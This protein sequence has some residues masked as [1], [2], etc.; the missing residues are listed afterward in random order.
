MTG[1]GLS[2]YNEIT[3]MP[4]YP[5]PKAAFILMSLLENK[6]FEAYIVGGYVRD[7]L[8]GRFG[9][10]IDM[11][12]NASTQQMIELFNDYPLSRIG[13]KLGTIGVKVMD[14]WIEITTYRSEGT[15]SNY[16]HPDEVRFIGSLKDDVL[17]RDFTINAMA[18][19]IYGDLIDYTEGCIDLQKRQIRAIGLPEER[20][21][22]DALRILRA[23]R[24][25]V[26]LGFTIEDKTS[27]AMMKAQDLIKTLPIER[28]SVE[29]D[30]LIQS[31]HLEPLFRNYPDLLR[32]C[33]DYDPQHIQ[34][35]DRFKDK[36]LRYLC[37]L[38]H[39]DA[40]TIKSQLSHLKHPK[41]FIQ[42]VSS[43]KILSN[44]QTQDRYTM[45]TL[46][47]TYGKALILLAIE[48]QTA[49]NIKGIDPVMMNQLIE[50]DP[51]VNLKDLAINGDDLLKM[52][53]HGKSIKD[54][55]N[56][57]L[58]LVMRDEVTNDKT[59]LSQAVSRLS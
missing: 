51:C 41:R 54:I 7:L 5:I 27:L 29:F 48:Y 57:L 58:E 25:S 3:M 24:F 23:L 21:Q 9:A 47:G 28:I 52:G 35:I 33:I 39:L 42:K 43:L 31:D 38:N 34:T 32:I 46:L 56:K 15:S 16:R 40:E 8:L 26:Q 36:G 37:L 22:E 4:P 1:M 13:E 55:L 44:I 11:A 14:Q 30:K 6:G 49:L 10:D 19:N 20:F 2:W 12:T 50:E 53:H 59:S 17:R 18:I 45:K